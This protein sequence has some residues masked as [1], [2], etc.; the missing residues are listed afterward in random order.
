M[1]GASTTSKQSNEESRQPRLTDFHWLR[2][3]EEPKQ[4][5][6]AQKSKP[7][8]AAESLLE[9]LQGEW[10][11]TKAIDGDGGDK[12]HEFDEE[13]AKIVVEGK[14]LILRGEVK[15][16][17]FEMPM[18]LELREAASPQKAD[19]D[20]EPNGSDRPCVLPGIIEC[21]GKQLRIS[22]CSEC[23]AP[24]GK[25]PKF[26][27]GGN[28]V[29]LFVARRDQKPPSQHSMDANSRKANIEKT[30]VRL[31]SEAI[32]DFNQRQKQDLV[33]ETQPPL[34]DDEVIASI[35]A[36]LRPN[37][38]PQS[39]PQDRKSLDE[40]WIIANQGVM[41]DGWSFQSETEVRV[42]DRFTV[43][44]W[45]V[46]L[47][48]DAGQRAFGHRVRFQPLSITWTPLSQK[49]RAKAAAGRIPVSD[50]IDKANVQVPAEIRSA[51]DSLFPDKPVAPREI[52]TAGAFLAGIAL[53]VESDSWTQ[54]IP[55]AA[56]EELKR[57]LATDTVHSDSELEILFQYG[58]RDFTFYQFDARFEFPIPSSRYAL[59][60]NQYYLRSVLEAKTPD[61]EIAWGPPAGDGLQMGVRLEKSELAKIK[62]DVWRP[63]FHFRN[64][65]GKTIAAFEHHIHYYDLDARTPTGKSWPTKVIGHA[66]LNTIPIF[67]VEVTG[68][69]RVEKSGSPFVVTLGPEPEGE[70]AD[71]TVKW[72]SPMSGEQLIIINAK[73]GETLR[74]RFQMAHPQSF[75][76]PKLVSG[77]LRLAIGQD[78]QSSASLERSILKKSLPEPI[79]SNAEPSPNSLADLALEL[80]DWANRERGGGSAAST[81]SLELAS[82]DELFKERS[83]AGRFTGSVDFASVPNQR[84]ITF[85]ARLFL[86][87]L[88]PRGMDFTARNSIRMGILPEEIQKVAQGERFVR[89]YYLPD[90]APDLR[91]DRL[92]PATLGKN[93]SQAEWLKGLEKLGQVIVVLELT[94]ID[95]ASNKEETNAEAKVFP[96]PQ[97]SNDNDMDR[98]LSVRVRQYSRP[99]KF[100]WEAIMR[101][102]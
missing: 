16:R 52:F 75:D 48:Y 90:D 28:N 81:Y 102:Y 15:G 45:K 101:S 4:Q 53:T 14:L 29:W 82:G 44:C 84:N 37:D 89:A 78:G 77:E 20:T 5:P 71:S 17:I 54:K 8:A 47:N 31:L 67:P 85:R 27:V 25:R 13:R 33:G 7:K 94:R 49:P 39:N 40:L 59:H 12:L 41:P 57:I 64:Q 6:P 79:V 80:V 60:L 99:S 46:E 19:F 32:R 68:E 42:I 10:A 97:P 88:S 73:P 58:Q 30:K 9:K 72:D 55:E 100:A 21:D 87:Q 1:R 83:L 34:T 62:G 66:V 69:M 50:F 26:F 51:F 92:K 91:G 43:R 18:A 2:T 98:I 38:I 56:A 22:A 74:L 24:E 70:P 23:N 3:R 76:L 86:P 65:T 96:K 61:F 36:G 93:T 63:R 35:R 11:V 95:D